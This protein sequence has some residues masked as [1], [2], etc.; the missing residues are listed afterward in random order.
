MSLWP[1]FALGRDRAEKAALEARIPALEA[2]LAKYKAA[3]ERKELRRGLTAV[4]AALMLALGFAL[5]AYGGLLKQAIADLIAAVGFGRP[6]QDADAANA[7][8]QKGDYATALRLLRPLADRG[9]VRAQS[10]LGLMYYHGR[11]VRQDNLEAIKWFRP[12]AEQG[13]ERAQFHLGFMYAEG[14]VLPQD[15]AEAAKW[16]RLSADQGYAQALYNLGL[17]YAKGEGVSQNNVSAHTWF[18]LAAAR[19]P[20]SDTGNRSVA[21]KN[22]DLVASKMTPEEIAEAQTLAREWKPK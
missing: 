11:G 7:A 10:T 15:F 19:F 9:D 6:L 8:Y 4:I 20:A 18:N 1:R 14:Q 17:A 13:D 5:G 16:Y 3:A 2:T 22:R 21:V 12:A